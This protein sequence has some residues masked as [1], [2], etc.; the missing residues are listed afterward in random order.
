MSVHNLEKFFEPAAVA[1]V[2]AG[3]KEKSIGYA[4]LKNLKE[5]GYEGAIYAVNPRHDQVMGLRCHGSLS[6]LPGPVDLAIIVTPILSVPGVIKEA[7]AIGV[8]GAV[9][10]SAGGKEVGVEGRRIEARL[11]EEA[12]RGG[13]R[14]I[15]PN[16]FGVLSAEHRLNVSFAN[17]MLLPGR[18]AFVSQSGAICAAILDYSLA[19]NIGF[20]HFVSL[21][22]MLDVDFGDLIDYLGNDRQ[23]SA[24]LLYMESLTNVRKFMS[25]ARAVA[26]S[27]PIVVLKAG[28]SEAGARAAASH[29]GALAGEDAVYDEAFKRAGMV[30]VETIGDLFDCA[31]L[32]A[33]QPRPKG[34]A[35]AIVTNAG[36]PGVMA[37][38]ALA[39][40]GL[41]PAPLSP[42][43]LK[44]LDDILPPHWSRAN[45]IDI[46][47]DTSLEKMMQAVRI[48]MAAPEIN[49]LLVMTAPQA[50][51][52]PTDVAAAVRDISGEV[53]FPIFTVWLG[54]PDVEEGRRILNQAGIPTYHTPEQ[55]IRAF[56]Y[57]Y[58][59]DRNLKTLQE[60]PAKFPTALE[61]DRERGAG[62]VN[63]ALAEDRPLLSEVEAK[64]L[65]EAYGIPTIPTAAAA[66]AAG[67]RRA[68]KEIG[69]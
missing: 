48:C 41:E 40:Y 39:A 32:M 56:W 63:E 4:V 66:S 20:R 50:L 3:D 64:R 8:K 14:I 18:L 27:K 12:R 57:M 5:A 42:Q 31:E 62:L 10:I 35:L 54:G 13:V 9:V 59:Y 19:E 29:T 46:V 11:E 68:A 23:V 38:D 21:G 34:P 51:N 67:G 2:G 7:A 55:A 44:S 25:A 16:C 36:G 26:R 65:L 45:P 1:V 33:K 47:G 15:G 69:F 6:R 43:T 52:H 22:S 60:T 28:R 58:A 17:R 49:A 37:A 61:F 53:R 30:R 24:I